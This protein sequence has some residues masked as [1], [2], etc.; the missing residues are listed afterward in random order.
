MDK[1]TI[2]TIPQGKDNYTHQVENVTGVSEM[3]YYLETND[4]DLLKKLLQTNVCSQ[5]GA[6]LEA[7]WDIVKK[8]PYLV[9][10]DHPEHEGIAKEYHEPRELNIN[11]K[12][13]ELMEQHGE[14]T[15]TALEQR[16]LPT[17]GALTQNQAMQILKLVYPEVPNDE[18]VR[19]AIL[20]R[21]FGL[22][23]LMK[24]VYIIGFF[25]KKTGKTD[26]ATVLGINATRQITASKGSFSYAD[27]TPRVMTKKEQENILG[28]VDE[29]KIWAITKL[30]T[31]TGLR[32]QGYGFYP[33]SETPYGT[34]KGNTKANMAFIRSERQAFSR[35]F[36]DALPQGVEVVDETYI[37]VPEVGKV[38]IITSEIT[39][40]STELTPETAK[41][42]GSSNYDKEWLR[43]SLKTLQEKNEKVW[44][45]AKILTFMKSTYKV[46]APTI[47]EAAD[48]LE[49][50]MLKHFFDRVQEGLDKL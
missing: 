50:G 4:R 24:Q 14:K 40:Q 5:C 26:Y 27:N 34:D 20:C 28:E 36:P 29:T 33:K 37:D 41:K 22:H 30:Q 31:Q 19:C 43:E 11:S 8:L 32:A 17:S 9:C 2:K 6:K 48:K 47:I 15:A 42:E 23:P 49:E 21:D 38:K 39:E 1:V 25:N 16:R 3:P 45:D 12:R 44:D 13:E 46:E 18:I 10:T 35:L 7:Y